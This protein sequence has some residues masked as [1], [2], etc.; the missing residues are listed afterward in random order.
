MFASLFAQA[1]ASNELKYSCCDFDSIRLTNLLKNIRGNTY[2]INDMLIIKTMSIRIYL[3]SWHTQEHFYLHRDIFMCNFKTFI[4]LSKKWS[5]WYNLSRRTLTN[6][7]LIESNA[8]SKTIVCCFHLFYSHIKTKNRQKIFQIYR[9][10]KSIDL[11][12]LIIIW[13][14]I[15]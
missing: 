6:A 5:S 15:I 14:Y 3:R 9:A 1:Y 12:C 10:S 11:V 13:L 4:E 7:A 8:K 2:N